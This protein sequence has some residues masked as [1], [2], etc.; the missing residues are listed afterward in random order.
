MKYSEHNF[1]GVDL[2]LWDSHA[3]FEYPAME[4]LGRISR[5]PIIHSH[6]AGMPD[7]HL[8]IGATVGSVIATKSAIIPAAVGVDI[9]CG[10]AWQRTSLTS[11]DLPDSLASLRADIERAVPCGRT[12]NGGEGDSGAWNGRSGIP[13]LVASRWN[14]ELD[15]GFERIVSK[16]DK[17]RKGNLVNHLGTLGGGNHFIEICLDEEDR[18]SVML[19]SGS[20]GVGNRIGQHF[21]AA[22]KRDFEERGHGH[23]LEDK[24]QAY[25][26]ENTEIFD[27]YINAMTW[28]QTFARINREIMMVRVL[29]VLRKHFKSFTLDKRAVNCHHNYATKERHFDEDVWITRKGAVRAGVDDYGIIPG[30]MGTGSFIVR[31]LGNEHSFCSCSHGAGRVMSRTQARKLITL[32]DH[33]KATEGIECPKDES[34]LDESPAAYKDIGAVMGAQEDLVEIVHRL[35]QIVNVKG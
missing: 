9:G 26:V 13:Q 25:L 6:I 28:A 1:G 3:P 4:Q 34:I 12:N 2:K 23:Y 19:H 17:L 30:S 8:G 16:Y 18:V 35:R 14:D 10:M 5:L 20:R 27:D 22:A 7:V 21:I 31:G 33:I 32:D 11:H 24:D 29:D 15:A